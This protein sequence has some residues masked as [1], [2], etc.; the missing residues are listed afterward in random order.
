MFQKKKSVPYDYTHKIFNTIILKKPLRER[1]SSK[2]EEDAIYQSP[3]PP[4]TV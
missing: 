2:R 3:P 1:E 4:F